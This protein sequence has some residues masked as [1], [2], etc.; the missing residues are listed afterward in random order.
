MIAPSLPLPLSLPRLR[1]HWETLTLVL[2]GRLGPVI[3]LG[4]RLALGK[5]FFASALT[6]LADWDATL[7]LFQYEYQL[8]LLPPQL[9]SLLGTATELGMS[10]LLVAGLATR[11]AAAALLMLSLVIEFVVGGAN[12]AYHAYE[13][14]FWI[15][16]LGHLLARGGGPLSC[17]HLVGRLLKGS[18]P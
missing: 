12:P 18:T 1:R 7:Y 2:A 4:L 8:P 16:A 11:C 3:D 17:D 13:H 10:V 14:Y 15:L 6:K 9:A 5:V